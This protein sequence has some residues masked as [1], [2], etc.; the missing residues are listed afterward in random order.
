[1]K[2]SKKDIQENKIF[3]SQTLLSDKELAD[4]WYEANN[5]SYQCG[6]NSD[7][8]SNKKQGGER[9]TCHHDTDPKNKKSFCYS[10]LW[11]KLSKLFNDPV[12]LDEAYINRSNFST[13][14]LSH[15]DN[16]EGNPSILICLNQHW[17]RDWGGYTVFFDS[18][19]GDSVMKTICPSPGQVV[20][21]NGSI[22][23]FALPP[24]ITANYPRYMLVLRAR[25]V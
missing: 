8:L 9:W 18:M 16:R 23:H 19:R 3:L 6:R 4:L 20:I 17:D 24:I 14:T 2:I 1:M 22:Y 13:E 21:F 10:P 25:Y 12:G 11:G 7:S 15:C 5:A